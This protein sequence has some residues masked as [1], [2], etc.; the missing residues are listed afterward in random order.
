[1]NL[2]EYDGKYVR[3]RDVDGNDF[4]GRASYGNADFLEC[5]WGMDEDGLFIEDVLVCHSQIESIEE[6]IPHGTAELWTEHLV[7]RRY[8]PD[9]AEQLHQKFG[10][11]PEMYQYSGWNP[12]ETP[13]MAQ[14]TVRRFIDGYNGGHVYSWV[15]DAN[16]DDVVA[17]TIGAYDYHN[18][19]IEVGFSVGR[20]W[21]GRGFATEAL[22][23]VLAYLTQNE[24]IACVTAWCAAENVGSRRVLEKSGMQ[25][26]KTEKDGLSIADKVY[27]RMIYEYRQS[28]D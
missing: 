11:D 16:G 18:G 7:L 1:M 12:Y 24:G 19:Q 14:E 8:R 23:T 21:Q 22:K 2:A 6:I 5:E 25:L 26:V 27:D 13:E 3:I 10:T 9:D 28:W 4:S 20:A 15:M 17:G